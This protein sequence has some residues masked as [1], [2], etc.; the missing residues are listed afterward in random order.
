MAGASVC[1][2][3]DIERKEAL[4]QVDVLATWLRGIP[5]REY[6]RPYRGSVAVEQCSHPNRAAKVKGLISAENVH[7]SFGNLLSS[8]QC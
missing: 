7:V 5:E 3:P 6:W 8:L 2:E 1:Y 4:E